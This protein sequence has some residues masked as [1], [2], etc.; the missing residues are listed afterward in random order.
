MKRIRAFTLL[1]ILVAMGVLALVL[2]FLLQI[3]NG[4]VLATRAGNHRLE[5]RTQARMMLEALAQDW[6]R[7]VEGF[8]AAALVHPAGDPAIALLVESRGYEAGSR[9]VAVTYALSG[10]GEIRQC[11]ESVPWSVEHLASALG[12]DENA[13]VISRG[14]LRLDLLLTLSDGRRVPALQEGEWLSGTVEGTALPTGYRALRR[15]GAVRVVALTLTVASVSPSA[16]GQ[17][18]DAGE[19][20]TVLAAFPT[21]SEEQ[22]LAS[23]GWQ[24][25]LHDGTLSGLPELAARSLQITRMTFHLP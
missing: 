21:G 17:L 16:H 15:S 3:S 7:Q 20:A 5:A 19:L 4:T 23:E 14:I 1:E 22:P 24:E 10:G 11:V 6:Q 2:G 12:T 18:T 13:T 25:T 8:G 9:F